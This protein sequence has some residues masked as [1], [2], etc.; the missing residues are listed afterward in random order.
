[1][2]E[3]HQLAA[4]LFTDIVGYTAIMQRD[5]Q[6]AVTT[7]KRHRL[8][9]ETTVKEHHGEIIEYFGDGSLCIFSSAIEAVRC[10]I[11]IQKQVKE[12]PAVPLRIGVHIGEVFFDDKRMMGDGVNLASRIQSLG[13]AGSILFSKEIADKIR[14]HQEFKT[15]SLGMFRLKNVDEPMEIFALANEGLIV[16]QK[17][18]MSDRWVPRETGKFTKNLKWIV[19]LLAVMLITTAIFYFTDLSRQRQFS[20]RDK[21]IAVLPFQ[22]ISNDSTQAYFSDGITEEIITQLS[23][24]ADLRVISR[25]SVMQY[26]NTQKNIRQ[27]AEELRVSTILE[28][29]V[30]REGDS[31]RITA[32]LIDAA[33]D[34]HLWSEKYDRNAKEIFTIQSE[35]A[36]QIA[37]EMDATLTAEE[38]KRIGKKA[39]ENVAAY[40]DYLRAKQL[41]LHEAEQ[42]LLS[43][44]KKDSTFALAWAQLAFTYSKMPQLTS[45]DAP[46]YVRKS[47]DA[48]LKAVEYG[49]D[50]SESHMI[51][52]DVLKTV[53]LNPGLSIK[54]L[55]K[56]ITLNPSNAEAYVF[57]AYA[58]ME[59]GRFKESEMDLVKAGQLA[60]LSDFV[61]FAWSRYYAYSRNAEKFASSNTG[62]EMNTRNSNKIWY[63]FLKDQYDSMLIYSRETRQS[64]LVGIAYSKMGNAVQARKIIDSL[65]ASSE[66]DHAF[67]IGIIYAW[68]GEKQKA[69]EYLNLAYRLYDY[70]LIS[71]KVNKLF[72]PLRGEKGFDDLLKK[73]GML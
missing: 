54:E 33:T 14:N 38:K 61:K 30:R 46:F 24:I 45:T 25:T 23:K 27:I 36:Q 42:W 56:S 3:Q 40:E 32:Q 53:T 13:L 5:E 47:L 21:S 73:M 34:R 41:P 59:L 29:S 48:A 62:L 9:L 20:G 37:T 1:M 12:E 8:V 31:V 7:I 15:E 49:P 18:E 58:L 69:L 44:L 68:L 6:L 26:K 60:P 70:N 39:T 11:H 35:V 52:G 64:A 43:A 50:I 72:D 28:G 55:N 2:Q 65:K 71:I 57:L 17:K 63:Y 22:N 19:V 51:L 4:I 66:N 10:A 67:A 16:P